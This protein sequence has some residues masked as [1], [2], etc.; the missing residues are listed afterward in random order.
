M[1]QWSRYVF[2]TIQL[3]FLLPKTTA[4]KK[5]RYSKTLTVCTPF[6]LQFARGYMVNRIMKAIE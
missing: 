1:D 3:S 5:E 2:F 6:I 4:S